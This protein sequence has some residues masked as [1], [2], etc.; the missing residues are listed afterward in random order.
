[1]LKLYHSI[2]KKAS[3]LILFVGIVITVISIFTRQTISDRKA[4]NQTDITETLSAKTY[5]RIHSPELKTKEQKL[6]AEM[7][8]VFL[9][10]LTGSGCSPEGK[11]VHAN[12]DKSFMGGIVRT[13]TSYLSVPPASGVEWAYSGLQ[14]AGFVP[15]SYAATGIG[16]SALAPFRQIWSV[17]RNLAY[18]VLVI[19]MITIGFMI[20]L[21]A[22]ISAQTVISVENSLPRIVL[23]L[24]L[25]TFS[26]AI[27]GF[28]IDAM[29]VIT[30]LVIVVM[31][32]PN[33]QFYNPKDYIESYMNGG[34]SV[35]YKSMMPSS[36]VPSFWNTIFGGMS[37]NKLSTS[38]A[39]GFFTFL[40]LGTSLLNFLPGIFRTFLN[41]LTGLGAWIAT[42]EV[43]NKYKE[44]LSFLNNISALTVGIGNIP[45]ALMWIF[46][47]LPVAFVVGAMLLPLLIAVLIWFTCL[48]VT[49]RIFVMVL[50][51]YVRILLMVLMAPGYMLLEAMPGQKMFS[52]WF[53]T[54]VGELLTFPLTVGIFLLGYVIVNN[55]NAPIGGTPGAGQPVIWAPP[56][57][58]AYGIDQFSFLFIVGMAVLFMTPELVKQVK[59]SLGIKPA[60]TGGFGLG[61][62]LGGGALA[63]SAFTGGIGGMRSLVTA[64]PTGFQNALSSK[65]I[66]GQGTILGRLGV[67]TKEDQRK[68]MREDYEKA[69]RAATAGQP[70][71]HAGQPGEKEGSK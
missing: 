54:L 71:S 68:Q 16:F 20:M 3:M 61:T 15:K 67:S 39:G 1:M 70:A 46:V 26:Y 55:F 18:M 35:I 48:Y 24:L 66:I 59:G 49:L 11:D 45:G 57:L 65:G 63:L 12:F 47:Y 32:G 4:F 8:G 5:E 25:I 22:K 28:L 9:C 27:A 7:Y 23:S 42:A 33:N 51:A 58:G 6:M 38:S 21:R 41:L 19:V 30:G 44:P 17:F 64:M 36:T 53:K 13:G 50:M 56:L 60:Q 69:M 34:I 10:G 37:D 62:F 29:Y 14:N 43:I 2:L 52:S 31:A 40:Y